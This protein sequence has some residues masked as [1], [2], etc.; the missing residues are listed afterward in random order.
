MRSP[1]ALVSLLALAL[2]LPLAVLAALSC[3]DS[4]GMAKSYP[5]YSWPCRP[6][7][8]MPAPEGPELPADS[9]V[10]DSRLCWLKCQG[11]QMWESQDGQNGDCI[12]KG[13]DTPDWGETADLATSRELCKNQDDVFVDSSYHTP[14]YEYLLT[15]LDNCED[16]GLD[17][18]ADGGPTDPSDASVHVTQYACESC[19]QSDLCSEVFPEQMRAAF[20]WSETRCPRENDDVLGDPDEAWRGRWIMDFGTGESTCVRSTDEYSTLC[21]SEAPDPYPPLYY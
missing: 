19:N 21:V 16:V 13:G 11:H 6:D 3:D 14:S 12:A 9:G 5:S 18:G 10:S 8:Y 2:I 1:V 7:A 4:E 15:L 20:Y 17:Y